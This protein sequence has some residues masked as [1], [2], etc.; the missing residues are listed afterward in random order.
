M[1]TQADG[2]VTELTPN[3]VLFGRGAPSIDNEGNVRFRQLVQNRKVEYVSTGKR[4][5]K[6]VIA[7]QVIQAVHQRN[8]RF[9]RKIESLVEAEEMGV[10]EG[11][12]AWATVDDATVLSKVKQALRDRELPDDARSPS[13]DEEQEGPTNGAPDDAAARLPPPAQPGA[14]ATG[15]P[16]PA[17]IQDPA[18][19]ARA[20]ALGGMADPYAAL[21]NQLAGGGSFG[22]AGLGH[23]PMGV[24]PDLLE[25]L[26]Y[27]QG[28]PGAAGMPGLSGFGQG[29][30][31]GLLAAPM[32]GAGPPQ[33][34][35]NDLDTSGAQ[36]VYRA[37]RVD[38]SDAKDR[39]GEGIALSKAEAAILLSLCER[40]LPLEEEK[41]SFTWTMFRIRFTEVLDE[42][43]DGE[44]ADKL[45]M[46]RVVASTKES[47]AQNT[48]QL[49]EQ[50]Y[51]RVVAKLG[52]S[53]LATEGWLAQELTYSARAHNVAS[54]S[55]GR[56]IPFSAS[57][58]L[59]IPSLRGSVNDALL[60]SAFLRA[61]DCV[62]LWVQIASLTRL[63]S[64]LSKYDDSSD[65]AELVEHTSRSI[66]SSVSS[67][68]IQR[69][70]WLL[71]YL[72]DKGYDSE[73]VSK[74]MEASTPTTI[75]WTMPV[76]QE[77]AHQLIQELHRQDEV[78]ARQT[79]VQARIDEYLNGT[80][81]GKAGDRKR[82]SKSK[83]ESSRSKRSR[84][85]ES[86]E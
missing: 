79:A 11:I 60:P 6:D 58:L 40:G 78:A 53:A 25:R 18:Y 14:A 47:L 24:P 77:R 43:F 27:S 74:W 56:P 80:P 31:Q 84:G 12:T 22:A 50:I 62:A 32:L 55:T 42:I 61:Q 34:G 30:G 59:N 73:L 13:D 81:D 9:L 7:R 28:L 39:I 71:E 20:G 44:P 70:Q 64:L 45:A 2:F 69:D 26:M 85:N 48:L 29:I 33:S 75:N 66:T 3:D 15:L 82:A 67:T 65:W 37:L 38:P 51:Q 5:I 57:D 41:V 83:A 21:R 8:G 49:L 23:P 46:E 16:P 10:P 52:T 63:Q 72:H 4:Q 19:L 17:G 68:V 86:E 35:G 54:P 1:S 76:I 36:G